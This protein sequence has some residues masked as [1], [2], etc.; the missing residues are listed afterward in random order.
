MRDT[1]IKVLRRYGNEFILK[2]H[3]KV[4]SMSDHIK[5]IKLIIF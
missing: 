2:K 3:I 1:L 4:R 5:I